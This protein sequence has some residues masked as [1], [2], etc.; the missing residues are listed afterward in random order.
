MAD[1]LSR[2]A[3]AQPRSGARGDEH[4][5]PALHDDQAF[6][7]EPLIGLGDGQRVGALLG[8]QGADRGQRVAVA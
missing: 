7:L 5:D 4:A 2:C 3:A 8:G 1:E 6:V